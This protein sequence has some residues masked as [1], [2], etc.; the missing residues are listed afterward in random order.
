MSEVLQRVRI[1]RFMDGGGHTSFGWDPEDDEWVLPMI[2]RKMAQGYVFWIVRRRPLREIQLTRVGEIGEN[3]HVIIRD[4]AS[5][6]LFEQG[7]IALAHE[8]D[9]EPLERIGIA[10][11]P[12][13]AVASDTIAHRGLRGG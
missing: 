9:D 6:E 2:R 11:T 12:E 7:R 13:E 5:R 8:E 1:M 3:R 10:D 4:Q